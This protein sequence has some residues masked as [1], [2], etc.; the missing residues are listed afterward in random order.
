MNLTSRE[1]NFHDELYRYKV[2]KLNTNY[3]G[4]TT[5]IINID[6][7]CKTINRDIEQLIKYLSN[8][9]SCQVKY[10]KD[11]KCLILKG[12]YTNDVLT[13]YFMDYVKV[14]VLCPNCDL[15]ETTLFYDKNL[16]HKCKSCGI[17]SVVKPK[18]IDKTF[19]FIEK[20]SIKN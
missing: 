2:N 8:N 11:N 7:L 13:K 14:Y 10:D 18:S 15:P 20:N 12:N 19:L 6:E 5:N 16:K 4:N 9:I 3:K 1:S 17:N